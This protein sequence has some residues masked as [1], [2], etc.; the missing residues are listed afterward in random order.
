M[1]YIM[2][3]FPEG[4]PKAFTMSY[5]DGVKDDIRFIETINKYNLKATFN[6]NNSAFGNENRLN[7]QEIKDYIL[8]NGHE[9]AIHGEFH[10][11]NGII[12]PKD[13]I[14]DVLNC[15]IAL[16]KLSGKIIRGMAYPDCGITRFSQPT[17]YSK[18]KNYLTDLGIAY[19]RTLSGDNNSFLLPNDW[20]AW[21]PTAHHRNPKVLD[22]L[23]QFVNVD[24][25]KGYLPSLYPRLF[26]LWGHTY[27][28]ENHSEWDLL[29]EICQTVTKYD[30][31][32]FATNIEIYDYVTAYNSLIF[33]ADNS[34]VYNPTLLTVW[35]TADNVLYKID[36]GETIEIK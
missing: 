23:N 17:T 4:K 32:W 1:R 13:G 26:Y 27:E 5:D 16:E 19:S 31:I 6:L 7:E 9:I 34:L 28:F 11:A 22:Y 30:N 10:R 29:E 8:A 33:S 15:R 12:S 24:I 14:A 21:M 2:L 20:H 25:S 36:S 3:R 35:F 18:V